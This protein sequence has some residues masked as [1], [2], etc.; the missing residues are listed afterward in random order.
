MAYSGVVVVV[1]TIGLDGETITCEEDGQVIDIMTGLQ[2]VCPQREVLCP[3]YYCPANCAGRGVCRHGQVD[4]CECFDAHDT[5]PHCANSP[6]VPPTIMPTILTETST[7]TT[8]IENDEIMPDIQYTQTPAVATILDGGA[9]SSVY[10]EDENSITII[11]GSPT[12]A[13]TAGGAAVSFT[14]QHVVFLI[15]LPSLLTWM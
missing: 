13:M 6:I 14:L 7:P 5:S 3:G 10:D 15:M 12:V 11:I 8:M 4:G 9:Y 2:I 1:V